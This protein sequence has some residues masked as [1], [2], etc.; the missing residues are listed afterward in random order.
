MANVPSGVKV[1]AS[2]NAGQPGG[3]PAPVAAP[4]ASASDAATER[5][6]SPDSVVYVV[7]RDQSPNSA[8]TCS[9]VPPPAV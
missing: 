8:G 1:T 5:T 3:P 7:R 4:C 2:R 9:S 6:V